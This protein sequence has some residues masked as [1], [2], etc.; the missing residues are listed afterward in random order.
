M[1]A[2]H[3]RLYDAFQRAREELN[4]AHFTMWLIYCYGVQEGM[5]V[6]GRAIK[7]EDV[8]GIEERLESRIKDQWADA[9]RC[10]HCG[11]H[12]TA[13]QHITAITDSPPDPVE[14]CDDCG[15]RQ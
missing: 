1:I 10:L 2:L 3:Q 11:G 9:G 5:A 15:G 12:I 13:H 8:D 6:V 14:V 7:K 4:P